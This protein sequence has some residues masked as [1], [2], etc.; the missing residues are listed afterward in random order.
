M[1]LTE[2]IASIPASDAAKTHFSVDSIEVKQMREIESLPLRHILLKHLTITHYLV[3]Q[4][5]QS[6]LKFIWYRPRP[7]SSVPSWLQSRPFR[8]VSL[9]RVWRTQERLEALRLSNLYFRLPQ[10]KI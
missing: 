9:W 8:R 4:S 2:V 7:V 10:Q 1:I 3:G 5:R 6:C